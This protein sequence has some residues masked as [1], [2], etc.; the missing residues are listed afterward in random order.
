MVSELPS[1]LPLTFI[2]MARAIQSNLGPF[3]IRTIAEW[4]PGSTLTGRAVANQDQQGITRD[5]G[6]QGATL[7]PRGSLDLLFAQGSLPGRATAV[8][9]VAE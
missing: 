3:E 5:T 6:S 8:G 2:A 4:C 1:F 7:A 9:G